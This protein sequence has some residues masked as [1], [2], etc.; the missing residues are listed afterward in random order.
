M[1]C[2]AAKRLDK[3]LAISRMVAVI[4]PVVASQKPNAFRHACLKK[5]TFHTAFGHVLCPSL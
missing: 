1:A 3:L 5:F 2:P 4:S